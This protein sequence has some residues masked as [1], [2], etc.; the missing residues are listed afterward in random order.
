MSREEAR[1]LRRRPAAEPVLDAEEEIDLAR[2]ATAVAARWWLLL[3]GLV[4]G[5]LVGYLLS[6]GGA[7]VYRAQ[8]LVYLGDPLAPSGTRVST[9]TTSISSLRELVTAEASVRRAAAASGLRP[10]RVRSGIF[11]QQVSGGTA[12]TTGQ[13]SLVNVGVRGA[14]PRRVADAANELARIA[15]ADVSRYVNAKIAALEGQIASANG[16]LESL[17][18]RI[19]ASS[20]AA[21]RGSGLSET[22]RLIALFNAGVL[23]TR[24]ATVLQTRSDRQQLLA[25][26]ENVER[27][28]LLKRAVPR[29]VTAQ[30]RRNS[31]V[32]AGAIGL[33]LGL[34]AALLWEPAARRLGRA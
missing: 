14:A 2:Y 32:A 10:A 21:E 5:V 31:L 7:E 22:E 33:L 4:A 6:V 12:R 16:E 30:S 11:L 25:L 20:R 29:E 23:E 3:L 24:R 8:A 26:A 15:V 1:E 27:P 18:R 28:Q 9:S 34:F 17:D 13:P 19:E